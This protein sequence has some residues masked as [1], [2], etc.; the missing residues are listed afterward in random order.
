MYE[1]CHGGNVR[2]EPNGAD[3]LDLSANINPLGF[4]EGVEEAVKNEIHF[5]CCYPD[6]K[7]FR[8]RECIADF[9]QVKP[10]WIFCGNG[11]SDIIFRLPFCL[12]PR[13]AL[14]EQPT[15]S[16]YERSLKSYGTKIHYHKLE[17]NWNFECD[18][19][20]ATI[21]KR[22]L[23]DLIFLCNPNNPTGILTKRK[24][25]ENL[26]R[27]CRNWKAVLVVDEC[28]IDFTEQANDVT[29][30]PLLSEF[31]NLIIL[32]AFTKIFALPGIRLG[33]AI[34]N[35]K[36]LIDKLYFHGTD[37]AVSNLAQAAGTAALKNAET[38][39]KET[40]LFV[41]QERQ[42]VKGEL[43]NLK[44]KVFDSQANFL[45]IKSPYDFDLQEELDK[46]RIR[47]RSYKNI[48][49]LGAGF[50]RLALSQHQYNIRLIETVQKIVSEQNKISNKNFDNVQENICTDL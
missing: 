34:C 46:H 31:D 44:Y 7:S 48:D 33:Y 25:I 37:W 42:Y 11:S 38:Y 30:K 1:Y 39:L 29:M 15:F 19:N 28:F 35:N 36:E 2:F 40:V 13:K 27:S 26:L 23:V 43:E 14:I 41:K 47:I 32:K 16:D 9:E 10:E 18:E 3:F 17:E 49:G 21:A 20:I 22:E 8:L 45:F 12:K 6:N 4:P 5:C 50:Y 24:I